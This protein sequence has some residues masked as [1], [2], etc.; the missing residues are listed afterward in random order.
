MV[1]VLFNFWGSYLVYG[2]G[3]STHFKFEKRLNQASASQHDKL[4]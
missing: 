4:L 1:S 2:T 3:E